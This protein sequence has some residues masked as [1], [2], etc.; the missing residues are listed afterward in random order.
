[1]LEYVFNSLMSMIDYTKNVYP[2]LLGNGFNNAFKA[3]L[4]LLIVG[5][6]IIEILL[7]YFNGDASSE[8]SDK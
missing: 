1:M 3:S 4:F 8:K 7:D 5:Y 6:S 2:F